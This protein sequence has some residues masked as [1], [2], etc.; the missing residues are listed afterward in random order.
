MVGISCGES[1]LSVCASMFSCR[2]VSIVEGVLCCAVRV[3][4]AVWAVCEFV[5]FHVM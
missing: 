5:Y 3:P 1:R 4:T 2:S